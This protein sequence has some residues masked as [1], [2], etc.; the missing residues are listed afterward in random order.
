[1]TG[2]EL[3]EWL[4]AC[5]PEQLECRVVMETTGSERHQDLITAKVYLQEKMNPRSGAIFL[6]NK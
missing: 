1:M 3:L 5:T 4:Q 6:I 2:Q